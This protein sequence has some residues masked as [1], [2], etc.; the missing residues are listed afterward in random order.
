MMPDGNTKED[1]KIPD[2]EVGDK[3]REAFNGGKE[4]M[5]QVLSAMGMEQAKSFKEA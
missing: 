1:L 2:G 3:L 5:V 4:V